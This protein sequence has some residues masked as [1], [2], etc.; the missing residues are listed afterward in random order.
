MPG[1]ATAYFISVVAAATMFIGGAAAAEGRLA[2]RARLR[3]GELRPAAN[4]ILPRFLAE[5]ILLL[6]ELLIPS[7]PRTEIFLTYTQVFGN[8]A[9]CPDASYLADPRQ[10]RRMYQWLRLG[11]QVM[12]SPFGLIA[13]LERF[14]MGS[15]SYFDQGYF[16]PS[17]SA[18]V[19]KVGIK[20]TFQRALF[21]TEVGALMSLGPHEG[22]IRLL[23]AAD[24]GYNNWNRYFMVSELM[25]GSLTHMMKSLP[26]AQHK[27]DVQ[28]LVLTA[29]RWFKDVCGALAHTH[30]KGWLHR[31]IAPSH[32][33]INK[34]GRA[35]LADWSRAVESVHTIAVSSCSWERFGDPEYMAPEC[36][37][38]GEWSQASDIFA[39]CAVLFRILNGV[40]PRK[41]L[42]DNL[43]LN[44]AQFPESFDTWMWREIDGFELEGNLILQLLEEGLS[45]DPTKR[46]AAVECVQ[47]ANR[48]L[49]A[50]GGTTV[51]LDE[52]VL[53]Q[54]YVIVEH[55][56][57]D[58]R[59]CLGLNT[60]RSLPRRTAT[61]VSKLAKNGLGKK[62]LG[63][64]V[65][66]F[67]K[68]KRALRS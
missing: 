43:D 68:I 53:A 63:K 20:T 22:I 29:F 9:L 54:E 11:Y 26:S 51:P 62:G 4:Q 27:L 50:S 28:A 15:S 55:A 60:R 37:G 5:V 23:W 44:A 3:G 64:V 52:T 40:A 7:A 16:Q 41:L 42:G 59:L 18:S 13:L 10:L 49:L 47:R 32:I 66:G 19:F 56:D 46:P 36:F 65:K 48:I 12:D 1:L 6:P 38:E 61:Q 21:N 35:V 33:L 39:A 67:G 30:G 17:G 25:E 14:H 2:A 45:R 8:L 58:P 24:S 57:A 34:Y 31:N